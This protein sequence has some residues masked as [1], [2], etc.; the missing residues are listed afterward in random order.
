MHLCLRLGWAPGLGLSSSVIPIAEGS[1]AEKIPTPAFQQKYV[2]SFCWLTCACVLFYSLV[3]W[4]GLVYENIS[5]SP[6]NEAFADLVF[7]TSIF[8][9]SVL[10]KCNEATTFENIEISLN[11]HEQKLNVYA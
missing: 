11:R 10:K 4:C 7:K 2:L 9:W 5:I 3:L 1:P 6:Q 8:Y